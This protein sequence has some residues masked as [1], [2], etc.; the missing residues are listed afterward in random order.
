MALDDISFIEARRIILARNNPSSSSKKNLTKD[1]RNFPSVGRSIG[2]VDVDSTNVYKWPSKG[3]NSLRN[4]DVSPSF[5]LERE[6][7]NLSS[8]NLEQIWDFIP[9][10][11]N[12]DLLLQRIVNTIKLHIKNSKI[13]NLSNI[14]HD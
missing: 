2:I 12:Q 9:R 10:I 7:D 5:L 13:S 6:A 14:N 4:K 3:H 8:C 11:Q 1:L